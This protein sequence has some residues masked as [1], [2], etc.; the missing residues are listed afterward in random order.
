M[1]LGNKVPDRREWD[2]RRG[3]NRRDF[4]KILTAL[5]FI[6]SFLKP[7]WGKATGS[8]EV[9]GI[10]FAPNVVLYHSDGRVIAFGDNGQTFDGYPGVTP[11]EGF[12]DADIPIATIH[13]DGFT[14]FWG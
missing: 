1:T 13:K 8:F 12:I 3:M 10:G 6:P 7:I 14:L 4:L 5:P 9:A 11:L 2:T